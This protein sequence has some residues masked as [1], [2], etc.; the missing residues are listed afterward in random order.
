M[1]FII[2]DDRVMA[3]CI[4]RMLRQAEPDLDVQIFSNGIEA[5]AALNDVV[6]SLIF[7]DVLLDGPDGFTVLNELVSYTDTAKIPIVLVS[8]LN[9]QKHDLSNYGVVKILHKDTMKPTDFQ[10]IL[11]QYHEE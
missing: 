4:A 7:L 2:D 8:S 11:E 1:I 6:P 5:V 9:L 3:E 10:T